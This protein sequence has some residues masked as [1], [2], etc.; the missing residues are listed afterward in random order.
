MGRQYAKFVSRNNTLVLILPPLRP[1]HWQL[2]ALCGDPSP[3]VSP[4]YSSYTLPPVLCQ[5]D[6]NFSQ[7]TATHGRQSVKSTQG[8][9]KGKLPPTASETGTYMLADEIA[10]A[11]QPPSL[12]SF[13]RVIPLMILPLLTRGLGL[14]I[15]SFTLPNPLPLLHL[16]STLLP[17]PRLFHPHHCSCQPSGMLRSIVL[18]RSY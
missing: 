10:Y 6:F 7:P 1:P 15:N 17:L 11:R 12:L 16:T 18:N 2:H 5:Y 3:R 4:G 8:G 13:I 14:H 9:F